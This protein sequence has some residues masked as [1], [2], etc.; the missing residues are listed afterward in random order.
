MEERNDL[1]YRRYL[2]RRIRRRKRRRKVMI[3]RTITAVL[4]L[5]LLAGIGFGIGKLSNMMGTSKGADKQEAR[6]SEKPSP[7]P[8]HVDVPEGYESIYKELFAMREEY[9]KIDDVLR[10]LSQYPEDV[11]ELL[12]KNP[13]TL[14]FALDYP[15]NVGAGVALSEEEG[16]ITQEELSQNIPCFQQ[17]DQRW[18]YVNYGNNIIAINGCGPTCLSMVYTGLTGK[19]DYT[20]SKM[21]NFSIENNYYTVDAGTSW[22]LM[23]SGAQKL[24]L[25]VEKLGISEDSIRQQLRAGKVIISSMVPGDFTTTGHFIVLRGLEGEDS[26]LINDPNS[27]AN[28]QKTWELSTVVKQIKAAWGYTA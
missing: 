26:V 27:I 15:K 9:P 23:A 24:G 6:Q 2:Q 28:S 10:S 11:L 19:T 5:C 8:F 1:E 16:A 18:G 3:A 4:G 7:T 13:E 25:K 22:N 20:P 12:A 17:W 21:A 14:Q